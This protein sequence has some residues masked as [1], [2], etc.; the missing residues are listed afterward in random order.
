MPSPGGVVSQ[1]L[2]A[3]NPAL[4]HG[5]DIEDS[6]EVATG[7]TVSLA[8][9]S[10][11]RSSA[12]RHEEG[13]RPRVLGGRLASLFG[14][15]SWIAQNRSRDSCHMAGAYRECRSSHAEGGCMGV[16]GDSRVALPRHPGSRE[17][18]ES[19]PVN[20]AAA[21]NRRPLRHRDDFNF[22]G[23]STA[24]TGRFPGLYQANGKEV[25]I[26][27]NYVGVYVTAYSAIR[28]S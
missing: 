9:A 17:D 2:G 7:E 18:Y 21:V 6:V 22:T 4:F 8:T 27:I 16:C 26:T 24:C 5:R 13:R 25:D 3:T 11:S 12:V 28:H 14:I 19:M 1:N 10:S 23:R 20:I 15:L